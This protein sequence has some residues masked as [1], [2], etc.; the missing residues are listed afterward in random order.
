[1]TTAEASA[2]AI[3]VLAPAKINL[4]LH[5]TGRRADG[6]HLLDSLVVF[7]DIADRVT[8]A[9]ADAPSLTVSGPRAS[10]VPVGPTNLCLRAAGFFGFSARIHLEKHLPAEAGIGG[11]SADAAAVLRAL[12]RL[13]GRAVPGG[14]EV[15]GADVPVC[16]VE[17]AVRMRG[18]GERLDPVPGLGPLDAVL[19]N[20]G[21]GMPTPRV[22]AALESAD[23]PGLPDMP[24]GAA[25][26]DW[27]LAT[28]NDLEPPARAL[29][30]GITDT[31]AALAD[32][33]GCTLSRM[34]GSGATCFGLYAD[35]AAAEA[36]AQALASDH[37]DWWVRA[38]VL[39]APA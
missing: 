15:L 14:A 36:A 19:V 7:A 34:S 10:G 11:G 29:E 35:R 39:N 32:Q 17:G 25:L 6:Y 20:P 3:T 2:G 31:L 12:S 16:L 4:A 26:S 24:A 23:N 8:V 18:I 33:P 5:V 21:V 1:M 9:L 27:L 13:T 37:P 38:T 28:R 22:F 30:P